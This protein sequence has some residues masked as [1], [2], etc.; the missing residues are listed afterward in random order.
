MPTPQPIEVYTVGVFIYV[1]TNDVNDKSY[2]GLCAGDLQLRWRRHL[3]CCRF[4]EGGALYNAIRK[5]GENKFH[6]TS[7]WSGHVSPDSLKT[8]EKYFIRC[9]NTM[10]PNGYNLTEGGDG[11][12][13]FKHSEEYKQSMRDRFISEATRQKMSR[14]HKGKV[15]SQHQ[16]QIV[17]EKLRGNQHM[18]GHRHSEETRA[19]IAAAGRGRIISE[20]TRR[21]RSRIAKE[22]GFRPPNTPEVR[23]KHRA[24]MLGRKHT[25]EARAKMS[26]ALKGK[27]KSPE[28]RAKLS[29]ATKR[30]FASRKEKSNEVNDQP[31]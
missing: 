30:W 20:E 7:L 29:A 13:G 12:F 18:L 15:I 23:A 14:I 16:K 26:A 10:R 24:K 8:L 3:A 31:R 5:Y 11:S 17:A 9:L 27:V 6:I 1:I 21:K 25:A 2:V 22:K 19:K 4:G 28:H